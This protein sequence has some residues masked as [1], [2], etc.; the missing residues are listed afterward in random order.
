LYLYNLAFS[1][2]KTPQPRLGGKKKAHR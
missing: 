1:A 2:V